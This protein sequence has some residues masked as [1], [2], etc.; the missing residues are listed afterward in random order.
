MACQFSPKTI[1]NLFKT[2]SLTASDSMGDG[3]SIR[4]L[5]LKDHL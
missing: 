5:N 4:E 3:H 2:L 1:L